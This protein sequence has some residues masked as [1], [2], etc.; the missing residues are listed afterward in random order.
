MHRTQLTQQR[1]YLLFKWV[2]SNT[3]SLHSHPRGAWGVCQLPL[4]CRAPN[5]LCPFLEMLTKLSR[6]WNTQESCLEAKLSQQLPQ[7]QTRTVQF[8]CHCPTKNFASCPGFKQKSIPFYAHHILSF[9]LW[10]TSSCQ[11]CKHQT[12]YQSFWQSQIAAWCKA[13]RWLLHIPEK[14]LSVLVAASVQALLDPSKSFASTSGPLFSTGTSTILAK[15]LSETSGSYNIWVLSS[16]MECKASSERSGMSSL[17][18]AG[19]SQASEGGAPWTGLTTNRWVFKHEIKVA[20]A[21]DLSSPNSDR[22]GSHA[23]FSCLKKASKLPSH[24][25]HVLYNLENKEQSYFLRAVTV[26]FTLNGV[27]YLLLN[28]GNLFL[29]FVHQSTVTAWQS[30]YQWKC[31]FVNCQEL[32]LYK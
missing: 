26:L 4:E 11:I 20:L 13:R 27:L 28:S 23:W 3:L 5:C 15:T 30:V 17:A 6:H 7:Q 9:L 19:A 12:R 14:L 24:D 22:D 32:E 18:T 8:Y 25:W 16:N 31:R 10:M 1:L 29:W 2:F 21:P